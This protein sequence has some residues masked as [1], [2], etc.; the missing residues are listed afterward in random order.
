MG[1]VACQ[2]MYGLIACL[3]KPGIDA[4]NLKLSFM[5]KA[6]LF[7]WP[8]E[9]LM[10]DLGGVPIDRSQ[11][12][13]TVQAMADELSAADA[14]A[15]LAALSIAAALAA[16]AATG[17]PTSG[18]AAGGRRRIEPVVDAATPAVAGAPDDVLVGGDELAELHC[19]ATLDGRDDELA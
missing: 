17:G 14:D 10:K 13:D 6:S 7:R 2:Q 18:A 9:R 16:P 11:S 12:R 1:V 15:V 8:F 3:A 5:G 19:L 4:L